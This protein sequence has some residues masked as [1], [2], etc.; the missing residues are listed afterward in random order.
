MPTTVKVWTYPE[1]NGDGSASCRL[2]ATER[3][4][5]AY[6]T[7]AEK[8]GDGWAEDCVGD[9]ELKFS[10]KGVLLNPDKCDI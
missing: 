8:Y 3:Q 7:K 4:A 5:R 1:N 6:A 10:D 2:F 9:K